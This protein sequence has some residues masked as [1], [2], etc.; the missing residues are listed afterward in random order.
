MSHTTFSVG[1]LTVE[2]VSESAVAES[3]V[4]ESEGSV[5]ESAV[6]QSAVA[7]SVR[8][9]ESAVVATVLSA[10][11]TAFLGHGLGRSHQ[12]HHRQHQAENLLDKKLDRNRFNTIR[13]I[14][15]G[16]KRWRGQFNLVSTKEYIKRLKRLKVLDWIFFWRSR[17]ATYQQF[18]HFSRAVDRR[19]ERL[20]SVS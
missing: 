16:V 12:H 4:A 2:S 9:V 15:L 5:A 6:A 11:L 20:E 18:V 8:A 17:S 14:V 10:S 13:T 19:W 7:Q 3:A 1:R